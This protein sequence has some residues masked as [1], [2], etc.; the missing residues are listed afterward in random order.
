MS[1]KKLREAFRQYLINERSVHKDNAQR[2]SEQKT[3]DTE[4]FSVF[5]YAVYEDEHI[6]VVE[7]AKRD[8]FLESDLKKNACSCVCE[9]VYNECHIYYVF[10]K[11]EISHYI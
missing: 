10:V 11:E 5:R 7:S 4:H 9:G 6:V 8:K 3:I 1:N 2:W